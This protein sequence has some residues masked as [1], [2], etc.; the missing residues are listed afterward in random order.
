MVGAGQAKEKCRDGRRAWQERACGG[1]LVCEG[2]G[3]KLKRAGAGGLL[4]A[5]ADEESAGA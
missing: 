3:W 2:K 1:C 4:M 5:W